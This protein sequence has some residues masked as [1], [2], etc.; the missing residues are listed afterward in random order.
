MTVINVSSFW[1]HLEERIGAKALQEEEGI[2]R[3]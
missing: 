3:Q 2:K 1:P